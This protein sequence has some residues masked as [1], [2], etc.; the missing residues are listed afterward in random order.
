[1]LFL[2]QVNHD[3]IAQVRL[4]LEPTFAA[5]AA[6]RAGAQDIARCEEANRKLKA[7][8][9]IKDAMI[10]HDTAIHALIAEI[11]G[12]RAFGIIM[13][14]LMDIHAYRMRSIKLGDKG[15]KEILRQHD[16]IVEAIRKK[17]EKRAYQAMR[18]HFLE[19]QKLLSEAEKKTVPPQPNPQTVK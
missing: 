18:K 8:F 16:R 4:A 2:G 5:Q 1:M 11:S 12:N 17:D 7:L 13:K 14:V 3:E 6:R 9:E 19:V 15:K 10:Q